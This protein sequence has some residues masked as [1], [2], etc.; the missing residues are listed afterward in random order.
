MTTSIRQNTCF[1]YKPRTGGDTKSPSFQIETPTTA[2]KAL[3][4][5][6]Q[7]L[8]FARAAAAFA[9]TKDAFQA[10]RAYWGGAGATRALMFPAI[11]LSG[12]VMGGMAILSAAI[13]AGLIQQKE[14]RSR[15]EAVIS[16]I[17]LGTAAFACQINKIVQGRNFSDMTKSRMAVGLHT[18]SFLAAVINIA[19]GMEIA[20]RIF[21]T[22]SNRFGEAVDKAADKAQAANQDDKQGAGTST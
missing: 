1:A 8:S 10:F 21:S 9:A 13:D 18:L 2:R 15:R 3:Y 6:R 19:R 4:Y 7:T 20:S 14:V 12:Q 11:H 17:A 22:M 5:L 16:E